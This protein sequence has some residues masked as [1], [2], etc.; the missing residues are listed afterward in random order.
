MTPLER[1]VAELRWFEENGTH[2][3]DKAATACLGSLTPFTGG[4]SS[5]VSQRMTPIFY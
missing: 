4:L 3:D 1:L 2:L 5:G